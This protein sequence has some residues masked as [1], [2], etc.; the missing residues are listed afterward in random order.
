MA[1][2]FQPLAVAESAVVRLDGDIE[3]DASLVSAACA[4]WPAG[5]GI[6][7]GDRGCV[8]VRRLR[9]LLKE[10]RRLPISMLLTATSLNIKWEAPRSRG[11]FKFWLRPEAT[12]ADNLI[13]PLPA[14]PL[15]HAE[16]VAEAIPRRALPGNRSPEATF[17]SRA[18]EPGPP[19]IE[20]ASCRPHDAPSGVEIAPRPPLTPV[21]VVEAPR[22]PAAHRP[23]R[24]FAVRFIEA[25][26]AAMG[27][28]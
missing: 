19:S 14:V 6:I 8:D 2:C 17:V 24:G 22:R 21:C 9:S 11:K 12:D 5:G 13:V 18:A 16:I 3:L 4:A 1:T 28:S 25:I 23:S 27:P 26:A 15:V 20:D 7:F 10:C